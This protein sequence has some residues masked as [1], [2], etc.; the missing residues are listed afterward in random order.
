MEPTREDMKPIR[1]ILDRRREG[2][3]DRRRPK[4]LVRKVRI[5]CVVLVRLSSLW[6][7]MIP[8]WACH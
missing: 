8:A 7:A 3:R 4:I 6:G 2:R 1:G 5:S